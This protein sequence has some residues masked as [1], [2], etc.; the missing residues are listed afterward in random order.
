MTRFL[1]VSLTFALCAMLLFAQSPA[2][3]HAYVRDV[4]AEVAA[5]LAEVAGTDEQARLAFGGTPER[6]EIVWVFEGRALDALTVATYG[7][8]NL[9]VRLSLEDL[10]ASSTGRVDG[11]ERASAGCGR[12]SNPGLRAAGCRPYGRGSSAD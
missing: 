5:E 1:T 8:V 10:G 4:P 12:C 3:A 6:P 2:P 7:S 11:G 9:G